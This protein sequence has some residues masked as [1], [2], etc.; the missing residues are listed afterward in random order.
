MNHVLSMGLIMS[1]AGVTLWLWTHG[2][3]GVGAVAAS[4][5]LALRLNGISH[6]IMWE[7]ASLFE[8]IGT[9]TDGMNTLSRPHAIVDAPGARRAARC[10]AARCGSTT[11]ASRTAAS[12]R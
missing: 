9:V 3:V 4:T 6:W 1:T 11:S 12:A 7:L 2:Q 10:R 8:N 5:A